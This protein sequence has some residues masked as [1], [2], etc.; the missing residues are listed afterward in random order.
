MLQEDNIVSAIMYLA[1]SKDVRMTATVL[2]HTIVLI[3]SDQ[4]IS[5][6]LD[7]LSVSQLLFKQKAKV[8]ISLV[9]SPFF[10]F[11]E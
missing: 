1:A 10:S 3:I 5:I 2:L 11:S 9:L 7:I 8:I 4:T 6:Y